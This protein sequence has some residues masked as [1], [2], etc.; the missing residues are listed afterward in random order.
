MSPHEPAVAPRQ[1]PR[2]RNGEA[3][4]PPPP[5]ADPDWARYLA[6]GGEMGARLR[7]FDWATTPLGPIGE[8]PSSLQEAVSLCLRSRFQLAISWGP[9]LVMLYNADPRTGTVPVVLLSARAGEES[10]LEGLAARADDYLVKPF[11]ARA[12]LARVGAHLAMARVRR[13]ELSP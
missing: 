5:P 3:E 6:A 12:L 2:G 11:S 9:E 4:R 7:S 13:E 1:Y 10:R 8:W